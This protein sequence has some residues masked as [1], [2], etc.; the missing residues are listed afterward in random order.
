MVEVPSMQKP[1]QLRRL[2]LAGALA[3][4]RLVPPLRRA[5]YWAMPER[6]ILLGR[7]RAHARR[8][9]LRFDV[10]V[11]KHWSAGPIAMA[12][13]RE[14][15]AKLI[16]DAN[17]LGFAEHEDN[18]HWQLL[19]A[20]HVRAV[21]ETVVRRADAMT[22]I[23]Q[24]IAEEYAR[25]YG[26]KRI[27]VVVRNIID[28]PPQPY[29]R[30]APPSPSSMV[31][32]AVPL[33]NLEAI[34]DSTADWEPGRKL[35]LHLTGEPGYIATL[36]ARAARPATAGRVEFRDPVPTVDL[37]ETLAQYDVGLIPFTA[38]SRQKRFAEP[39][40]LYQYVSAGLAV[41][42]TPLEQIARHIDEHGFGA[43]APAETP[44]EIAALV[45]GLSADA[46][47]TMKR[48]SAKAA[49]TF[50]WRRESDKLRSVIAELEH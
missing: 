30:R 50:T 29:R 18:K 38:T 48:N 1:R 23:G 25:E 43:Y 26:L 45:N 9:G 19:A 13:A 11:A 46:I 36:R 49:K 44:A 34:I 20:K 12:M 2:W 39:N 16:Y 35:F 3:T 7:I 42:S 33:R 31:G 40:K 27:P 47:A 15:G 37:P 14:H 6:A 21:E 28:T 22:T 8:N 17:E 5:A 4:S 24:M 10:V 32:L 41:A